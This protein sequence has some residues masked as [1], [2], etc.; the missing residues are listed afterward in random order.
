MKALFIYGDVTK[1]LFPVVN[2]NIFKNSALLKVFTGSQI[3]TFSKRFMKLCKM[4]YT[5]LILGSG[6]FVL[7]SKRLLIILLYYNIHLSKYSFT[8]H[9]V[10]VEIAKLQ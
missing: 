9:T 1:R 7:V 4:R 10:T 6:R 2:Q 3:L 8:L 5:S